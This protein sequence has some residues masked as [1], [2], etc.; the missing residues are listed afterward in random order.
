M[1][2]SIMKRITCRSSSSSFFVIKMIWNSALA[3]RV[4]CCYSAYDCAILY[5]HK[6]PRVIG[7]YVNMPLQYAAIFKRLQNYIKGCKIIK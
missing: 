6:D 2:A 4:K 7:L 3:L 5:S 1:C